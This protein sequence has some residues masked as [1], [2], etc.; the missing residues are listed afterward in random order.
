MIPRPAQSERLAPH[1]AKLRFENK[2]EFFL[3]DDELELSVELPTISQREL[4]KAHRELTQAFRS[5]RRDGSGAPVQQTIA[6]GE[7][8]QFWNKS[9]PAYEEA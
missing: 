6:E 1:E 9:Q 5:I 3:D 4:L 8:M 7:S 2:W